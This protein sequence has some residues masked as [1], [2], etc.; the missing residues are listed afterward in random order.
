MSE[1]KNKHEHFWQYLQ[2]V[3][4]GKKGHESSA[5][6]VRYCVCGARQHAYTERWRPLPKTHDAHRRIE[7]GDE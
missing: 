7:T 6:V 3:Y 2:A 4:E 1:R 5:S